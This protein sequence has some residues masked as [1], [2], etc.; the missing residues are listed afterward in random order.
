MVIIKYSKD[1]IVRDGYNIDEYDE[2]EGEGGVCKICTSTPCC[3]SKK[4]HEQFSTLDE[5]HS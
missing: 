5:V 1:V 2:K 4:G 3:K